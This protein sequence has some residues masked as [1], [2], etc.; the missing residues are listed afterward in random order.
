MIKKQLVCKPLCLLNRISLNE[1]E[2]TSRV[3]RIKTIFGKQRGKVE[4]RSISLITKQLLIVNTE[5]RK[6]RLI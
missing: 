2:G 5:S 3:R 4:W 1:T 6:I